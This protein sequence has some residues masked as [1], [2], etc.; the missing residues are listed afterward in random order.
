MKRLTILSLLLVAAIMPGCDK[1]KY[2]IQ[3]FQDNDTT[4]TPLVRK[5][6]LEDY[7]G[8]LCGN[9]PAAAEVAENIVKDYKDKVILVAVHAGWFSRTSSE[10]TTSYRCA[11]GTAWDGST[12]FNISNIGNPNGM[13]NRKD[14]GAGLV[15]KEGK[16]PTYVSQAL[17][18]PYILGLQLTPAYDPSTRMLNTTVKAT[19]KGEYASDVMLNVILVEDSLKSPQYKYLPGGGDIKVEN[20]VFMHVLRDA[21]NGSWGTEL[22][23]API[24]G[25]DSVTVSFNDFA[26]KPAFNDKQ[27]YLVAFAYDKTTREILQAEKIKL[28]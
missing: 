11:A 19:F 17:N 4:S 6:L 27:L 22:K 24:A 28:R 13:V 18:D 9:C 12:G 16:W 23:K 7:T 2:P 21:V 3:E 8:H 5:V 26:V 15:Q 25:K 14:Y 1:V 10:Y 20:Y